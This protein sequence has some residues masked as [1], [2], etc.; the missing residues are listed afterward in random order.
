MISTRWEEIKSVFEAALLQEE[1]ERESFV[2]NRCGGDFELAHQVHRLL[3]ADRE[4]GNFLTP[5]AF[6]NASLLAAPAP[7]RLLFENDV[8]CNRF[9]VLSYLGEG[10]MGQ[11]YKALDLELQHEIAVK[12]IRPDIADIPGVLSRFR[13]EVNATRKVTHPNVCRTFDLETHSPSEQEKNRFTNPV[14]FLTMELLAGE[15]VAEKI[16]RSG[17]L[18]PD[19]LRIFATQVALALQAAHTAGV[20]HCDLKPSNVFITGPERDLR[21]VVTDFGIAKFT[22]PQDYPSLTTI[23]GILG[24]NQ[25]TPFYMAPEQLEDGACSIASDIYAYGVVLFE[26]LTGQRLSLHH[27]SGS[28]IRTAL[29]KAPAGCEAAKTSDLGW[30]D[31]VARCIRSNPADRFATVQEILDLLALEPSHLALAQQAEAV[32]QRPS[33][34]GKDRASARLP[35]RLSALSLTVRLVSAVATVLILGILIWITKGRI[36]A[37]SSARHDLSIAVLPIAHEGNNASIEALSQRI[38]SNLTDDLAMM[39]GIRVPSRSTVRA[40]GSTPTLPSIEKSLSVQ[41][42]VNGAI[43][44]VGRA[45]ELQ[46]ELVDAKTGFQ[47][48]NGTYTE[49]ELRSS[50][51]EQDIAQDIAYQLRIGAN[52]ARKRL[53]QRSSIPSAEQS[54]LNGQAAL[55]EHTYPGFERAAKCFQQA[56][57]TDPGFAEAMAEL[58]HSYTLM[59]TNNSR[60]EPPLAL[61]NQAEDAARR[62]LRLDSAL[63]EAYSSLAQIEVLRDYNWKEAEEN[64]KR[65]EELDPAYVTGH[66]SHALHL[67]IPQGR[68]AEARVQFTYANKEVPKTLRTSLAEASAAYFERQFQSS[69]IQVE[70]LRNEFHTTA[71]A[72]EI[73]AL[74]Y[75]MLKSPQKAVKLLVETPPDPSA[76]PVLRA[77]L[78]GIALA[79]L[80]RRDAAADE[81]LRIEQV[82]QRDFNSSY[83]VAAL[84]AQLGYTNKAFEHLEKSHQDR[85]PDML[86]LAVDPLMDPLRTNPQFQTLLAALNLH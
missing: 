19:Q 31:I 24:P 7:S 27:R 72:I 40:L 57:D 62:A 46:I 86:F 78:R 37:H 17:P 33:I 56:I 1:Q 80:G 64:F 59:V 21:F 30:I 43:V 25:G 85:E 54:F 23:S 83:Y 74:D 29:I 34:A 32:Q 16:R 68:L 11:V 3:I 70:A 18:S 5:V 76:S 2:S 41:S 53:H 28:G 50:S 45:L 71:G 39:A 42:V 79:K 75:I 9:K 13:R 63:V 73:E 84:C 82:K 47:S 69:L 77:A 48:W 10:G 14:T 44:R 38:T 6:P 49:Q 52:G 58:S 81:L 55:A 65:A 66:V 12:A 4:S 36:D 35:K 8:L 20:I 51:I 61:M 60:P 22:N 67:L 26:V 15:T